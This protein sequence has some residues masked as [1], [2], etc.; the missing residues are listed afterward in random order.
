MAGDNAASTFGMAGRGNTVSTVLS[1]EDDRELTASAVGLEAGRGNTV[2]SL[3]ALEAGRGNTVS[4]EAA[5]EPGRGN[6]LSSVAALEPGPGRGNTVSTIFNHEPGRGNTVSTVGSGRIGTLSSTTTLQPT[7]TISTATTYASPPS[8]TSSTAYSSPV[9]SS[10]SSSAMSV[11]P[12]RSDRKEPIPTA[13]FS[14][15]DRHFSR[16]STE[17]QRVEEVK[18]EKKEAFVAGGDTSRTGDVAGW[19]TAEVG[20]W[21]MS[22]G[23]GPALTDILRANAVTG[24]TFLLLSDQRLAGMG[25][26]PPSAR[27]VI[28]ALVEEARRTAGIQITVVPPVTRSDDA[29]PQYS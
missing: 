27:T 13:L 15:L 28:M 24:S 6:T 14:G 9:P 29:P 12:V 19:S 18:G 5:L 7:N 1:L 4:S 2:S 25:I 16:I 21:L 11:P 17:V 26:E 23:I 22:V 10:E 20:E 8:T 3:G